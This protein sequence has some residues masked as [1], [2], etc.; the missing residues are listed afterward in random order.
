[1]W[2]LAPIIALTNPNDQVQFK[3]IKKQEFIIIN[4]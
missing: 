4:E 3:K 2:N 1:M